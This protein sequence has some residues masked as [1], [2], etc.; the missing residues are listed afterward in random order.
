MKNLGLGC[1]LAGNRSR[2]KSWADRKKWSGQVDPAKNY[3]PN[4][5]AH[6]REYSHWERVASLL[7]VGTGFHAELTGKENIFLNG[8][9]LGMKNHEIKSRYDEIVAYAEVESFW[10]H[11]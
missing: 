11:R 1:D 2:L 6:K 4:H 3:L 8:A 7:E 5:T 9:I 10:T